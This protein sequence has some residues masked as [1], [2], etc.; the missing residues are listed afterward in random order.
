MLLYHQSVIIIPIINPFGSE[1]YD[2][3]IAYVSFSQWIQVI[4]VYTL[5]Y[6]MMEPPLA[7]N[8]DTEE[9]EEE[10]INEIEEQPVENSL[11][12]PLLV[13]AELPG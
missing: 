1:C 9:E 10:E 13:E 8:Y 3:G 4:L 12:R 6:H 11:S 2:K 7:Y 5:V